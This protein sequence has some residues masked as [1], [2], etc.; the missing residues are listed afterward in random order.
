MLMTMNND[1]LIPV[2]IRGSYQQE[3]IPC[4]GVEAKSLNSNIVIEFHLFI[5]GSEWIETIQA[6]EGTQFRECLSP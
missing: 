6:E 3:G 4:Y 5:F 2:K 1:P